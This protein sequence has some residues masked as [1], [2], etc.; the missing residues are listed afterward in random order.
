MSDNFIGVK[1][2]LVNN[3]F[4]NV[5]MNDYKDKPISNIIRH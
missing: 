4:H 3:W 2:R 1:Y 5:N